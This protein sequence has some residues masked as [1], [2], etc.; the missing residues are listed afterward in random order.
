[1]NIGEKFYCSSC[2]TELCDEQVCPFCGY[3]PSGIPD[4]DALEEGTLL[5]GIQYQLGAVKMRTENCITYGAFDYIRQKTLF[6]KEYFPA[7]LATRE[8]SQTD[9]IV[10][11]KENTAAFET[12]EK[13]FIVL[14]DEDCD[15][16]QENGTVYLAGLFRH[17]N[18]SA[19]Y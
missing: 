1:M 6:I 8:I 16:F 2:L 13:K 12:G 19:S 4:P 11:L 15:I 3:D 17:M 9:R 14:E 18:N 7:D 5:N 10:V